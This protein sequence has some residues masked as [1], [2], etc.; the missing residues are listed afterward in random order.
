M[1]MVGFTDNYQDR[2]THEGY[3]FEFYCERCGNGY[4][5]SFKRSA[6]N[7]G[8]KLLRMGGDLIGG[9]WGRRASELGWDANW[10]RRDVHIKQ[11]LGLGEDYWRRAATIL[12]MP[13]T[14]QGTP[15]DPGPRATGLPRSA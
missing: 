6:V 10:M 5:S 11:R 4:T 13:S 9:E 3:Q 2:S 8:G 12:R 1:G 7:F 15:T 14:P